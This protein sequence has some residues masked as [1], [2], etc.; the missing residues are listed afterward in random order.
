MEYENTQ[1]KLVTVGMVQ[2][3]NP[4]FNGIRKYI[5]VPVEVRDTVWSLNPCFNGIRKYTI[6]VICAAVLSFVLILVL[7]EYENTVCNS[8]S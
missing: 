1:K 2:S 3:L 5:K 7:M 6:M 4:C 8:I